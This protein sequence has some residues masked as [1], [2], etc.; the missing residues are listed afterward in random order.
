MSAYFSCLIVNDTIDKAVFKVVRVSGGSCVVGFLFNAGPLIT[1]CAPRPF[2]Q[3]WP[4]VESQSRLKKISSSTFSNCICPIHSHDLIANIADCA[5]KAKT[6]SWHVEIEQSIRRPRFTRLFKHFPFLFPFDI[7]PSSVSIWFFHLLPMGS[8]T[9]RCKSLFK[10]A[11]KSETSPSIIP[12]GENQPIEQGKKQLIC[13]SW[14]ILLIKVQLVTY[15]TDAIIANDTCI[16][17]STQTQKGPEWKIKR[18]HNS[19]VARWIASEKLWEL[20]SSERE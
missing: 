13:F 20:F 5:C 2:S 11:T 14:D 8:F 9:A 1:Y 10:M 17:E 16:A 4:S 6:Q 15:R 3:H 12:T 18:R 19:H 7:F